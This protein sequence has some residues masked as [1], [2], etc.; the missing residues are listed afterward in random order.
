MAF[1]GFAELLSNKHGMQTWRKFRRCKAAGNA[2]GQA[3]AMSGRCLHPCA[4]PSERAVWEG[5]LGYPNDGWTY[6]G[7]GG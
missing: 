7:A 5:A 4:A 1:E 2:E 6:D 3:V